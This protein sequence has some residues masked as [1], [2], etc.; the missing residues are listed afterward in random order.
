MNMINS[1]AGYLYY[2]GTSDAPGDEYEMSEEAKREIAIRLRCARIVA[3]TVRLLKAL[4]GTQALGSMEAPD[5]IAAI[6]GDFAFDPKKIRKE[7]EAEDRVRFYNEREAGN[8]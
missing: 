3:R 5:E 6:L 2:P 7:I 1:A 8:V 4:P